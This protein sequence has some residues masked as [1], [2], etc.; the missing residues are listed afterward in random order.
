[1]MSGRGVGWRTGGLESASSSGSSAS[2][3]I[4]SIDA[5]A[6]RAKVSD[7]GALT[8]ARTHAC[9]P[10]SSLSSAL[11]LSS[12][13]LRA[14][15]ETNQRKENGNRSF[16]GWGRRLCQRIRMQRHTRSIIQT[17]HSYEIRIRE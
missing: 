6:D 9:P 14:H 13:P 10:S 15:S 17:C 3:P 1:M 7:H 12:L 2:E 8:H 4:R 11:S 5:Q 16:L